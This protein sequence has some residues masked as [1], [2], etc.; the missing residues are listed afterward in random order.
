MTSIL[1]LFMHFLVMKSRCLH[2]TQEV[3]WIICAL[4]RAV[5]ICQMVHPQVFV[6]P[7]D[8]LRHNLSVVWAVF[9]NISQFSECRSKTC[10][11]LLQNFKWLSWRF[12]CCIPAWLWCWHSGLEIMLHPNGFSAKQFSAIHSKTTKAVT[13]P[14]L[15]KMNK[16]L[17]R[18]TIDLKTQL[19]REKRSSRTIVNLPRSLYFLPM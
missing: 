8:L 12:L 15:M 18:A 17:R 10:G 9:L 3:L 13:N 1:G 4:Y 16:Y 5:S 6:F 14:P 19:R 11:V 7:F 2:L